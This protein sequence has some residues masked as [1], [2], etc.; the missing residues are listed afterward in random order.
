[1][2]SSYNLQVCPFLI[3]VF[4]RKN[5]PFRYIMCYNNALSYRESEFSVK[6]DVPKECEVNI[7]TW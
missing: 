7:H 1:M 6:G 5:E 3:R 2:F 4:I